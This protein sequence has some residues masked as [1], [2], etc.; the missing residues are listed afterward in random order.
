MSNHSQK[1]L[2]RSGLAV[3]AWLCAGNSVLAQATDLNRASLLA[4]VA[5][6]Y[7]RAER[8]EKAVSLLEQAEVQMGEGCYQANALLKIGVGY[9]KAGRSVKGEQFL[10]QAVEKA[11][12][13]T[14]ENCH[15]GATSPEESLLNR[16]VEYAEA[17]HLDL[18]LQIAE[19]VDSWLQPV[20][21][22]EIAAYYNAAGQRRQAKQVL[23]QAIAIARDDLEDLMAN[24]L[25]IF[26]VD[27]LIQAE[28]PELAKFLIDETGLAQPQPSDT[29][30]PS[31]AIAFDNHL[32]QGLVRILVDLDQPQQALTLLESIVS[33]IQPSPDFPLEEASQLVEA[34]LLY[35]S[36]GQAPQ[37]AEL[38][39]KVRQMPDQSL[40][41]VRLAQGYAALGEFDQARVL[42]ESIEVTSDRQS[43]YAAIAAEYAKAGLTQE[44]DRLAQSIGGP[45]FVIRNMIRAYLE[46]E[47][48]SQAQQLA[49][50]ANMSDMSA[51]IAQAYL[52]AGEPEPALQ[53]IDS[54]SAVDLVEWL[55]LRTA[56]EFAQQGQ[57]DQALDQARA[58][59]APDTKVEALTAI[60]ADYLDPPANS[61][62]GRL[63]ARLVTVLQTWLGTS[64]PEKAVE[65]LDEALNLIQ[66]ET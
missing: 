51:E 60:A 58:I 61:L 13:R 38:L 24:Q 52:A 23:T 3:I 31:E 9:L 59:A 6:E 22:A 44:A 41:K 47:Q 50:Q 4:E 62:W 56:V 42:A 30:Q 43:A 7:A 55:R 28:Q 64:D 40:A 25:L 5:F 36:L 19:R 12:E 21:M 8:P 39:E 18:A 16:A 63:W 57:F 54:I 27:R 53:I 33:K 11:H 45:D 1:W 34:A 14:S 35:N 26:M 46:T 10:T 66:S 49:Q 48:Y 20:A 65:L 15:S 32:K 29:S 37:A 17:D 2:F